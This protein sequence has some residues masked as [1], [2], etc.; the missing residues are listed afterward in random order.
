[1]KYLTF[2]QIPVWQKAHELTLYVYKV[3]AS[4]PKTEMYGLI[5]QIQRSSSSIPANIAEGFYR[6]STKELV[7]YLFIAR[8]SIGETKYH[9]RLARDL[10]YLKEQDY[11][12]LI[13]EYENVG[14]QLNGWIKSL[15]EKIDHRSSIINHQKKGGDNN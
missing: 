14:K 13:N 4:F 5:S 1:M 7:Q 10:K 3:T 11:I 15:K 8:G 2:E 9:L 6:S 12:F